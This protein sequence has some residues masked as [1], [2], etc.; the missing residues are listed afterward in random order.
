MEM[1]NTHHHM[2]LKKW[3]RLYC[4][5][6]G[7]AV[8]QDEYNRR[9]HAIACNFDNDNDIEVIVYEGNYY[10]YSFQ[11]EDE[12][13]VFLVFQLMLKNR[14]GFEDKFCG[15]V[16]REIFHASFSRDGRKVEEEG[17]YNVDVWMK[18]FIDRQ[19]MASLHPDGGI[20]V[21]HEYFPEILDLY[22]FGMFLDI[23]RQKGFFQK[24]YDV[25]KELEM[26]LDETV[27]DI[28]RENKEEAIVAVTSFEKYGEMFLVIDL[29]WSSIRIIMTKDFL[30]SRKAHVDLTFLGDSKF[31]EPEEQKYWIKKEKRKQD[32]E[33]LE[34]PSD[35]I[36]RR[37]DERYPA[38]MLLEYEKGGGK[39]PLVPLLS[40][41]YNKYLELF[42]KAGLG[43]I[44]SCYSEISTQPWFHADGKD[45]RGIL[46]LPV[47]V[48]KRLQHQPEKELVRMMPR[49]VQIYAKKPQLLQMEQIS[50]AYNDMLYYCDVC[51]T[52]ESQG[53]QSIAGIADWSDKEI[54]QTLR[55][56]SARSGAG[57]Y[58]LYRDY[59]KIC[60]DIQEYPEGRWPKALNRAHDSALRLHYIQKDDML[61]LR[62]MKAVQKEEYVRLST[63]YEEEE[64]YARPFAD[65][66]EEEE[67]ARP[68]ADCEEEEEHARPSTDCEEEEAFKVLTPTTAWD[69]INES[70]HLHHCVKIYSET[71]AS[72]KTYIL[73]LR[74]RED[75]ETPF[76]TMEVLPSCTEPGRISARRRPTLVQLKAVN[77][78]KAPIEA[79]KFVRRW[80]KEK[81]VLIQSRDLYETAG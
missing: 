44:C 28:I 36:L 62:F 40:P 14:P 12:K 65:C 67:H 69:L 16:W 33:V 43:N 73:F 2:F 19:H 27:R 63:D 55:Y 48:L 26:P 6:C 39:N 74:R 18:K 8:M 21:I 54:L 9:E 49:Y 64:E 71:V 78:T 1:I 57:D 30:V 37:F 31:L 75:P 5:K 50:V 10:A 60:L 56:L 4:S 47:K 51:H 3:G 77:N 45:V 41:N 29:G 46:G 13:L 59:V 68:S 22:S 20:Q 32:P 72:G 38:F 52:G 53:W 42:S 17:Q 25:S 79:Q 70:N 15:S 35:G 24:N 80:A 61:S 76:A 23:Y 34:Y 7:K 11:I 58:A 66:E 81:G